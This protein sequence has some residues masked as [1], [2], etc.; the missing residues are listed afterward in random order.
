MPPIVIADTG[1]NTGIPMGSHHEKL[2]FRVMH[3]NSFEKTFYSSK[4]AYLSAAREK[5]KKKQ[6]F[7]IPG[8]QRGERW[9]RREVGDGVAAPAPFCHQ[10][11]ITRAHYPTGCQ[12]AVRN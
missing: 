4:E 9:L 6:I 3:D 12:R 10:T 2:F 1:V 7:M 8:S 11:L 5:H